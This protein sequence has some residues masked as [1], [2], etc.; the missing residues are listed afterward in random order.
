MPAH[1]MTVEH[2]DR[3]NAVL[4]GKFF[5]AHELEF[6]QFDRRQEGMAY[7]TTDRNRMPK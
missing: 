3:G 5:A 6:Y 1:V 2:H 4:F 7:N